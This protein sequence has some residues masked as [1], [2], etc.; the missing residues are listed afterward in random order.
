[1]ARFLA[2]LAIA[3]TIAATG[4][5]AQNSA[6]VHTATINT[7]KVSGAIATAANNSAAPGGRD[8]VTNLLD[9]FSD[10]QPAM[11]VL[12]PPGNTPHLGKDCAGAA[13]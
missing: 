10:A 5:F 7:V 4:A 8:S 6:P 1:M 2:P 13:C 9:N 11:P 12:T 3:A